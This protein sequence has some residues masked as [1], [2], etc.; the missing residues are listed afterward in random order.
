MPLHDHPNMVVLTR[1][2]YGELEVISYDVV[3]DPPT[4]HPP[5]NDDRRGENDVRDRMDVDD[6]NEDDDDEGAPLKRR[7][8]RSFLSD[9][10]N[11]IRE[12]VLNRVL[13]SFLNNDDDDG[14]GGCNGEGM[15]GGKSFDD[16]V[17]RARPN[18]N[19]M[20]AMR[21]DGKMGGY[22]DDDGHRRRRTPTFVITA[23]SV[24]CLYPREGNCH[25]FVAGPHGAAVLDVLFPPYGD[26][27]DGCT[28]Y[29]MRESGGAEDDDGDGAAAEEDDERRRRRRR[30]P[31]VLLSPIDQPDEFNCLGGS[32]G[33]FGSRR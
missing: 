5:N 25:A 16:R 2:L 28:Y 13:L 9:S 1:V 11:R 23:P 32:Y 27:D 30:P 29:E 21:R 18:L 19:P 15:H 17:L 10:L 24:T 7:R 6:D 3:D 26:D 4:P 33:R 8:S 20:G 31:L 14:S 12:Y 22:D